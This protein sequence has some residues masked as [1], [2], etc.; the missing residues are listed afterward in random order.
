LAL[1]EIA[2]RYLLKKNE[3]E[4]FT[5]NA[6]Q[7][8]RGC[9]N[10]CDFCSIPRF[11][12]S[13][14]IRPV[15]KV[16]EELKSIK[17]KNVLFIDDNIVGNTEYALQ[18]FRAIAP[19]KK[20]WVSQASLKIVRE[21]GLLEAAVTSGCKGLFIGFE[22]INEKNLASINKSFNETK[23]YGDAVRVLHNHK[24]NVE[25]AIIFGFD[26]DDKTVFERTLEFVDKTGIDA[27]QTSILTPLPGTKMFDEMD[28]QGRIIDKEWKNYDYR[29]VVFKPKNISP[30]ELLNGT[31][32]FISEFYRKRRIAK[33]IASGFIRTDIM[34]TILLNIPVNIGY[35]LDAVRWKTKGT[36]PNA[37]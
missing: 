13:Y 5:I 23:D 8:S 33:R 9:E 26:N 6:I 31:E 32:W 28:R 29:H 16:I 12:G 19:L 21:K 10:K 18:L 30:E 20:R 14:R 35:Y 17:S 4:Y 3:K 34:G 11:Y 7:I 37:A 24:V 27:V 22:T 25:A 15:E 2:P 36:N 1:L